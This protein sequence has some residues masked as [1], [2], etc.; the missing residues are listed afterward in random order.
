MDTAAL[1]K[2]FDDLNA[3]IKE[4]KKEMSNKSRGLIDHLAIQFLV[5]CPEVTGIHWTQYT[6]YF[7][8]GETCEFS[9]N[10][11]YFHILEGED[12]EIDS[13]YNSTAIYTQAHLDEA[14]E[15][16][17]VAKTYVADPEAWKDNFF[18]EW[19]AKYGQNYPNS[20]DYLRPYPYTIEGA[21]ER[22]D[23]ITKNFE[24]YGPE[25]AQRIT[26]EFKVFTS[27]MAKIPDDIMQVV[28]GDHVSVVIN[29]YGITI[30]EYDHD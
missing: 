22:I 24:T 18:K 30:D 5:N 8:D 29:R 6:P 2:N 23:R 13:F 21:Q 4:A 25:V 20:R 12:D 28:F 15:K 11:Y 3:Q 26:K 7:N 19:R 9:V 10:G 14:L 16:L 17:E 27:A 1:L